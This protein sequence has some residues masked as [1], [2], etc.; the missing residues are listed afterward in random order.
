M[1]KNIAILALSLL[2]LNAL[3]AKLDN[4]IMTSN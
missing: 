4:S 3:T 2:I 1:R